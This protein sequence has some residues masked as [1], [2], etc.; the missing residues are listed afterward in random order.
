[1][2]NDLTLLITDPNLRVISNPITSWTNIDCLIKLNEVGSASFTAPADPDLVDLV[3]TPGNRVCLIRDGAVVCSGPIEQTTYSWDASSS[4]ST[5]PGELTCSWADNLAYLGWRVTY[6]DPVHEINAQ[7][8]NYWAAPANQSAEIT[9]R[10]LV[11]SNAG[12]GAIARRQIPKLILSPVNNVG[13][14][15]PVAVQTRLEVL[16]DILR[17]LAYAGGNLGFRINDT[18]TNLVFEVYRPTDR[19][20]QVVFSKRLRNLT[21]LQINPQAPTATAVL[22]GGSGTGSGRAFL[23]RTSSTDAGWGR[24]E[25][26][27][28]QATDSTALVLQQAGD[29][30]LADG[31]YTPGVQA[32]AVDTPDQRYGDAYQLGDR[33]SVEKATGDLLTD[34]VTAV[35]LTATPQDGVL[36]SPTIGASSTGSSSAA[37]AVVAALRDLEDRIS[38]LERS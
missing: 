13:T 10:Q 25:K 3:E 26:F 6:P 2:A 38:Q 11:N 20:K 8:T 5:E 22:I 35:H 19:S 37:G 28:N 31:A 16:T 7:A 1:M 15:I 12:A 29:Q 30:A 14:T 24:I 17:T 18:F 27:V 4:G 21:N 34:V 32:T 9:M 36:I 33:V 23:E